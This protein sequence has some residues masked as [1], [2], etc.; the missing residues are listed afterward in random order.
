MAKAAAKKPAARKRGASRNPPKGQ[1][2][3][4]PGALWLVLGLL[5]GLFVALLWHLWELRKD[6][7]RAVTAAVA[8]GTLPAAGATGQEGGG[9]APA[10]GKPQEPRFEFYTLLPKQEAMPGSAPPPSA[11]ATAS[12]TPAEKTGPG[13]LLQA[14]SFKSEEE[15]DKRRAAILMLGLP[16]KV[17]KVPVTPGEAWF[18]VMVGPFKGKSEAASARSSLKDNGVE[19]LVVK[20]G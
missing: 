6:H 5:T 16:V 4:A 10:S 8:P 17:T 20:Q 7:P 11:A 19:A 1:R 3:G 18:R 9:N 12:S 2:K 15:A 14:G 13:Y